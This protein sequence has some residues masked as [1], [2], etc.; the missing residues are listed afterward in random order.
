[1]AT[2]LKHPTTISATGNVTTTQTSIRTVVLT[3]AAAVATLVLR[4]GGSGGT[5]ILNLQASANGDSVVC[6]FQDDDLP[7]PTV[8]SGVGLHATLG[9]AGAVADIYTK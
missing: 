4:D 3:P 2:Q 9:G 6:N 1:M 8:T 5:V 7:V